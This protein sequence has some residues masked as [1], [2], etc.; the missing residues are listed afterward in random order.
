MFAKRD[1]SNLTVGRQIYVTKQKIMFQICKKF[2][3][4]FSETGY[5][6]SVTM[7]G[8]MKNPFLRLLL[9]QVKR[10]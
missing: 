3:E 8:S 7:I 2:S 10:K 1:K 4:Q 6:P 5:R 9:T